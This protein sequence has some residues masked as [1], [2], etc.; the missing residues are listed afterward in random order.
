[1]QSTSKRVYPRAP[2]A[3]L[4]EDQAAPSSAIF[5]NRKSDF[6][7]CI[8]RNDEERD[9]VY[10]G[11]RFGLDAASL[12]AKIVEWNRPLEQ[13]CLFPEISSVSIL[14][15]VPDAITCNAL[16]LGGRIDLPQLLGDTDINVFLHGRGSARLESLSV[17]RS[18]R[19][20]NLRPCTP[21]APYKPCVAILSHSRYLA[22]TFR[23]PNPKR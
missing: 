14:C 15:H 7:Q 13:V 22:F 3:K 8:S 16:V 23:R 2:W 6:L 18:V 19:S 5:T 11:F 9:E 1:M 10:S 21:H 12:D 4:S 20:Q 17:C